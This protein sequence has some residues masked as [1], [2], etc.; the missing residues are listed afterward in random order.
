[1]TATDHIGEY[2]VCEGC[3]AGAQVSPIHAYMAYDAYAQGR[4]RKKSKTSKIVGH[5]KSD[6]KVKRGKTA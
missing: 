5:C 4:T 1:M 2:G 3:P 6:Q